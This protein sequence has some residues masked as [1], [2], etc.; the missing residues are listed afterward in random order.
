V[1]KTKS[2]ITRAEVPKPHI[3]AVCR[4]E[5][6]LARSLRFRAALL[7]QE[8]V[9]PLFLIF[10]AKRR[11]RERATRFLEFHEQS[12]MSATPGHCMQFFD[13][14]IDSAFKMLINLT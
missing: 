13:G 2:Q 7:T 6:P 5:P 9:A 14:C 3:C 1:I 12:P 10:C 4:W 11:D 8:G